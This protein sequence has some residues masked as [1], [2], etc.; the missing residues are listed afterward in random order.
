MVVTPCM[1]TAA[2]SRPMPVSTLGRGQRV[3]RAVQVVVELHEHQIPQ[4][5]VPVAG[6][7]GVVLGIGAVGA[8]VGSQAPP[9]LA[10]V[11]V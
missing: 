9:T 6:V 10:E 11:V 5:H 1:T 2:R 4:L 8:A 3:A 7:A